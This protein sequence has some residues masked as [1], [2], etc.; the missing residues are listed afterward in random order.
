MAQTSVV[1]VDRAEVRDAFDFVSLGEL[2]G[3]EAYISLDTGKVYLRTVDGDVMEEDEV[4]ED[5]ETSD[6][7]IAV[8]HKAELDLGRRLA[9]RFTE[10]E[11]PGDYDAVRD[12]FRRKGAYSGFK[13]LL[14]ARGALQRWYNYEERAT[15]EALR[16]WC[17]DNGIQLIG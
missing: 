16:A 6:R 10:Q 4:P 3:A 15:E 12:L 1:K 13:R 17:E 5:V 11:L 2:L 8:P 7:Y 14:E 9:L